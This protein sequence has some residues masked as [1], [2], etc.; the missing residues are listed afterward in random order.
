MINYKWIGSI[1]EKNHLMIWG[2]I[3]VEKNG[4]DSVANDTV[5]TYIMFSGRSDKDLTNKTFIDSENNIIDLIKRKKL[6]GY[7]MITEFEFD[8]LFPNFKHT[9]K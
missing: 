3:E 2:I 5:S 6:K 7:N 8:N 4:F 9:L 1:P